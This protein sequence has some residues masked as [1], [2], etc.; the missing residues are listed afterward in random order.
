MKVV[1]IGAG[2]AGLALANFLEKYHIDYKVYESF[3][4]FKKVGAGILLAPNAMKAFREL[5]LSEQLMSTGYQQR[6]LRI[7]DGNMRPLS[8][9]KYGQGN[10]ALAMHRGDLQSIL[11]NGIPLSKIHLRK[12]VDDVL[13][14][15]NSCVIQF[16][17]GTTVEANLIIGADGI[18]SSVRQRIFPDSHLRDAA[19]LCWR[20]VLRYDLPKKYK[21]GLNEIWAG[22][23]RFGFVPIGPGTVYWYALKNAKTGDEQLS[24]EELAYQFEDYAS[25]VRKLMDNTPLDAILCN[26]LIDLKPIQHWHKKRIVLMGDAAHAVTPN[27]GQ[28]ACQAI[29]DAYVLSKCLLEY[30]HHEKAFENYEGL[31]KAKALKVVN[32]SWSIGKIAHFQHPLLVAVRNIMLRSLPKGLVEKRNAELFSLSG[33]NF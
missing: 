19:Q 21:S 30:N 11:L 32:S 3:P 14:I 7:V 13:D 8:S 6:Y 2:I 20:G 23:K 22:G 10:D 25:I 4:N 16:R 5:G 27:M 17:D 31:R 9:V 29:E 15:G 28:G 1:I 24:G 26:K 12:E 18:H 33:S